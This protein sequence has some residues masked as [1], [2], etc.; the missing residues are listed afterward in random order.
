MA[1]Q[2]AEGKAEGLTSSGEPSGHWLSSGGVPAP[3]QGMPCLRIGC[4][5]HKLRHYSGIVRAA[6]TCSRGFVFPKQPREVC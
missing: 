5:L 2:M 4:I 6:T 3:P 1:P